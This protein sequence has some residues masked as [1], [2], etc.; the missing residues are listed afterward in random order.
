MN[1]KKTSVRHGMQGVFVFVL[2]GLFA[3]MSTLMVLMGAQMYRGTVENA[4]VNSENRLLNA[5]VRSMVRSEDALDAVRIEEVDGV[6][7]IALYEEIDGE[8]YVTWMYRF[9]DQLYEQFTESEFDFD[10]TMGMP[11]CPINSFDP[12]IENGLLTVRMT[13]DK[14]EACTVQVALRCA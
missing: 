1:G 2:L 6:T 4:G 13:D 8:R 3:V 11:I 14:D 9:E 10:P 12:S 7:A 5:Y